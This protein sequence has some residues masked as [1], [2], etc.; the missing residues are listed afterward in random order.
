MIVADASAFAAII[1]NEAD[2]Q[3]YADALRDH[4]AI[5]VPAPTIFELRLV[6]HRRFGPNYTLRADTLLT[7]PSIQIVPWT[8]THVALAIEALQRFSGRPARLNFGDCMVYAVAKSL[9]LTLLYKG[10][11]FAR[12]DIRPA[13]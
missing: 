11:D 9:D 4:A 1:F 13:L 6:I 3:L 5:I 8:E 7:A 10:E 2:A 12:T